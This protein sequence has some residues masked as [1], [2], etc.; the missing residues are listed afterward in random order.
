MSDRVQ[1]SLAGVRV[2]AE[3]RARRRELASFEEANQ[4]YLEKSLALAR[5]R[6][7]M[8]P[9]DAVAQRARHRRRLLLR[10]RASCLAREI[11]PGDFFAFF[12]R[13]PAPHVAA[14]RARLRVRHDRARARRLHAP[15]RDLRAVPEW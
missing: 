3:L 7:S 10:R 11:T 9:D 15:R 5:L 14:D 1:A 4:D 2:G 8:G 6:G 12:W 13:L